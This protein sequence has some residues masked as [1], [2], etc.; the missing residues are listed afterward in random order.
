MSASSRQPQPAARDSP[1][2]P[3]PAPY[4]QVTHTHHPTV[5]DNTL[6]FTKT[7]WKLFTWQLIILDV[8]QLNPWW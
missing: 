3:A 7:Q 1:A 4:R 5:S 2:V 6:Y 8:P